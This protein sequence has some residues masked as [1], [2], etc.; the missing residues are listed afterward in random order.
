MIN[1]REIFRKLLQEPTVWPKSDVP[2][3]C[4][5]CGSPIR[6]NWVKIPDRENLASDL[7][8]CPTCGLKTFETDPG[9]A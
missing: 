7:L 8:A 9:A 3:E 2:L 4:D 1:D 5:I 6:G